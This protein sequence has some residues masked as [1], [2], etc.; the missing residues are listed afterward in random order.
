MTKTWILLCLK[1]DDEKEILGNYNT[2]LAKLEPL[3]HSGQ[4]ARLLDNSA[5]CVARMIQRHPTHVPLEEVLPALVKLLPLREDYEENTA[6]FEMV[7][8]LYQA[9]NAVMLGLTQD[10]LPI[11]QQVLGPPAEQLNEATRAKVLQL[12]QY[13]S[14]Q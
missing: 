9:N 3:L 4:G 2:I 1:S 6:V 10:L 8:S 14:S 7:V 11:M 13:L 12:V 5:G